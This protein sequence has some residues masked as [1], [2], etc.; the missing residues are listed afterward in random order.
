M[1]TLI[2]WNINANKI[3]YKCKFV[4]ILCESM[5]AEKLIFIRCSSIKKK[6]PYYYIIIVEKSN[7]SQLINDA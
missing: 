1:I 6:M 2:L 3:I 7:F 4:F 5:D